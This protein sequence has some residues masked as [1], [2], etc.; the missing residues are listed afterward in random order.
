MKIFQVSNHHLKGKLELRDCVDFRPRV[1]DDDFTLTMVVQHKQ[2]QH[3][4][5]TYRLTDQTL[6]VPVD[7]IKPGSD[8][9]CDLEFYLSRIDGI[10]LT[11]QGQFKQARGS[12]A[13]D[14]QRP[15]KMDDAMLL[16]YL[17]LPAYTF[18]T[19]DVTVIPIDNRR[20]T[21]RDIGLIE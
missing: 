21:M 19:S 4:L 1:G 16:Y 15:D 2:F 18:N 6:A 17:K 9:R 10:Y 14:P 3:S 11:K 20:Y 8:F 5:I 13:I 12:S 7:L